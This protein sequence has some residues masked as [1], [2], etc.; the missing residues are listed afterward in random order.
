MA[1]AAT[2]TVHVIRVALK[3]KVYRDIEIASAQTLHDLAEAIVQAFDFDFD[4]AFGFYSKLTGNIYDSP[5]RY[6]LFADMGESDARSVK[7]TRIAGALPSVGDKMRFLFDYGDEWHFQVAVVGHGQA[8][9]GVQ[10]PRQVA[11]VGKAPRQ[12]PDPD[13]E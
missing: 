4:H 13:D 3:P 1:K 9:P 7:K 12:Y 10:Y 5:L 2:K 6:E 11:S 8:Q